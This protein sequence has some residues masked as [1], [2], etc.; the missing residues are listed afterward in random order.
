[1]DWIGSHVIHH[2]KN[3]DYLIFSPVTIW[4]RIRIR[5]MRYRSF[6][7]RSLNFWRTKNQVS[8][9]IIRRDINKIKCTISCAIPPTWNF[10]FR[11]FYQ[12]VVHVRFSWSLLF[13]WTAKC[14]LY[15]HYI[16]LKLYSQDGNKFWMKHDI[17]TEKIRENGGVWID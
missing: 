2:T 6:E 3:N 5:F 17:K 4:K 15:Y 8:T 10:K 12:S 13:T 9:S 7:Y 11:S 14:K 16:K 1:M